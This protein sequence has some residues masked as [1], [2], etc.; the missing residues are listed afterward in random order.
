MVRAS[1]P[2]S[3]LVRCPCAE[4]YRTPLSGLLDSFSGGIDTWLDR[5]PSVGKWL[6]RLAGTVVIWSGVRM[7][8]SR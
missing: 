4:I 6:D 2:G 8:V 3:L 7:I 1:K 5:R